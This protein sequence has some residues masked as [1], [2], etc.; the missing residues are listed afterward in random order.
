MAGT[1]VSAVSMFDLLSQADDAPREEKR[2]NEYALID[3][4][5]YACAIF[6]QLSPPLC[7]S[8]PNV[9]HLAS[10]PS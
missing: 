1:V 6:L 8:L 9:G 10:F 5:M 3:L 2:S 7:R 4:C